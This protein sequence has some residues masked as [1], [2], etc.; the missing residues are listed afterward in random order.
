MVDKINDR[1]M[2]DVGPPT[3]PDTVEGKR[4]DVRRVI[5]QN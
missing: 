5:V 1:E 4:E 3:P 2:L